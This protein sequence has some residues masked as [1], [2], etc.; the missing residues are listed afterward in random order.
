MRLIFLKLNHHC[1]SH[2]LE[3]IS[4][5]LSPNLYFSLHQ[6]SSHVPIH[7]CSST[8]K[9]AHAAT[10]M[11]ASFTD[12]TLNHLLSRTLRHSG[13]MHAHTRNSV[14][15]VFYFLASPARHSRPRAP[16]FTLPHPSPRHSSLCRTRHL[17]AD[18]RASRCRP[19]A[20]RST[21]SSPAHA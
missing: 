19:P 16:Q 2:T 17:A 14:V 20:R 18:R 15:G 4:I 21:P 13:S 7:T 9:H 12:Q 8:R 6:V 11:D 5:P 10:C 1:L 3:P